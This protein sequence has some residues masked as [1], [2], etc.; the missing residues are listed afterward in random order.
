MLNKDSL[1]RGCMLHVLVIT[2]GSF[3]KG[4]QDRAADTYSEASVSTEE[5]LA[6][7]AAL[8]VDCSKTN[9][10]IGSYG[11]RRIENLDTLLKGP[12]LNDGM[13]SRHIKRDDSWHTLCDRTTRTGSPFWH[14]ICS[15]LFMFSNFWSKDWVCT[16]SKDTSSVSA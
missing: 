7:P 10:W 15:A 8:R 6:S 4:S 14:E 2:C 9:S 5:S 3:S 11:A 1:A 16:A 13:H 12:M